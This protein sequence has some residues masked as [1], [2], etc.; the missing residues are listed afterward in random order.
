MESICLDCSRGHWQEKRDDIEFLQCDYCNRADG[1]PSSWPASAFVD[2]DLLQWRL[3][4]TPLKCRACTIEATTSSEEP[5]QQ[6]V[7]AGCQLRMPVRGPPDGFSPMLLNELESGGME[8]RRVKCYQCQF[9]KCFVCSTRPRFP[10]PA[11]TCYNSDGKYLC[12]NCRYPAC[13]V[14]KVVAKSTVCVY[15]SVSAIGLQLR[16]TN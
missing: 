7:C 15:V 1:V 4:K 16:L 12:E 8:Q 2:A 9:P 5:L 6:E 14:C 13:D 11:H 10:G 3:H